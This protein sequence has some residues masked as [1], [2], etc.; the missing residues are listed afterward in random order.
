[1]IGG[2]GT[3]LVLKLAKPSSGLKIYHLILIALG[4]AG[5]VFYDWLDGF[6]VAGLSSSQNING[7][8]IPALSSNKITYGTGGWLS[9]LVGGV[10]TALILLWLVRSLNWKQLSVIGIGWA[11]GFAIGGWIVWT[12]GFPIALNY[13]YGPLY[14]NDPGNS[15]LILFTLI[16][17]LCGAFAGWSGGAATL[18]QFSIKP[19]QNSENISSTSKDQADEKINVGDIG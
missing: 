4:W 15:S 1:M 5:I 3:A 2:V 14:G 16:S 13:A 10:L 19:S 11:S 8:A 9:G 12:I 18:K 6:A 7:V 17:L